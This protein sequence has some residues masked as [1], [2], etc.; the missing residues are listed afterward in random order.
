MNAALKKQS[1]LA[2]RVAKSLDEQIKSGNLSATQM[3]KLTDASKKN[4]ESLEKL[5][6]AEATVEKAQRASNTAKKSANVTE[7]ERQKI[8]E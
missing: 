7:Q 1:E 5:A 4:A 6:K 8:I 2:E 3:K